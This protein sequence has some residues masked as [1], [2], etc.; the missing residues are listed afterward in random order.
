M[1]AKLRG[2]VA[3]TLGELSLLWIRLVASSVVAAIPIVLV[4]VIWRVL[5]AVSP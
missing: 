3:L 1:I 2:I 5:Q 4:L